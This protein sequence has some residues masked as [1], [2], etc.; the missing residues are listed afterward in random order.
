MKN[1]LHVSVKVFIILI[2][3]GSIATSVYFYYQYDQAIKSKNQLNQK[4]IDKLLGSVG[5]LI[6]LPKGETPTIATVTDVNKLKSQ[7]FFKKAQ[8]GDQVFIFANA[9]KA[10]LY[11]PAT[12][13]IID[14]APVFI[15][16]N[17][18][19]SVAGANTQQ[20]IA[21]GG[22]SPAVPKIT[23]ALY[24]GTETQGLTYQVE[25]PLTDRF[26]EVAIS[27]RQ[28]T[29]RKG[30]PKTLLVDISK[31][32]SAKAKEIAT[33]LGVPLTSLPV[34]EPVPKADILIIIGKDKEK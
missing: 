21:N 31:K 2:F 11:R 8:N 33:F 9:K 1:L 27:T 7:D 12:D 29:L 14:V 4:E 5:R 10:I 28:A 32:Q 15:S 23:V 24:N 25:T 26:G 17:K 3:L 18:N 20:A 13:K 19:G 6:E 30:Y 16:D 34:G 22:I